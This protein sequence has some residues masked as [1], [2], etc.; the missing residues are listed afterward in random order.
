MQ[1]PQYIWD[2]GTAYD[3][4]QSLSVIHSPANCGLRAAWAAGMRS[5]LPSA[6]RK[7][8]EQADRAKLLSPRLNWIH[9]LPAPKDGAM[10]LSAI[11]N[12]PPADRLSAMMLSPEISPDVVEVL[13]AIRDKGNWNESEERFLKEAFREIMSSGGLRTLTEALDLWARAEEFGRCFLSAL[14]SYYEV[15]FEEEEKRIFPALEE[16]LGRAQDMAERYVWLDLIRELSQGVHYDAL[17]DALPETPTELVLVPSFWGA[18]FVTYGVVDEQ[19]VII[20]FGAR[21]ADASLVPGEVVPDTLL[22]ALKA[23]SDP[24]R[25]RILRYLAE[26]PLTPGQLARRLRLRGPTVIYHLR[27]LRMATLVELSG[28]GKETIYFIR[29]QGIPATYAGLNDFLGRED[30]LEADNSH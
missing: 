28:F 5:R 12:I 19:R 7:T 8:L 29:D 4:F 13:E 20:T 27:I 24:T 21:P 16:A 15:F 17:L 30:N 18:P 25:L 2:I 22:R 6:D 3:M 26:E 9:N 14:T 23:L 11:E 1:S 10:V